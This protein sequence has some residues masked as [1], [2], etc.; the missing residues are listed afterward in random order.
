MTRLW[1]RHIGTG[2]RIA[3]HVTPNADKSEVTGEFDGALKVR[4]KAQP[5]E[6]RANDALVRLIATKLG[7]AKSTVSVSH[8]QSGRQKL[9][10]VST[11][12][13]PE[14]AMRRL[15]GNDA[16]IKTDSRIH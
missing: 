15:L 11:T 13:T 9:L 1:C 4:L 5:L 14:E 7:V 6:G 2:L 10:A 3:V 8:G 16:E 12:L